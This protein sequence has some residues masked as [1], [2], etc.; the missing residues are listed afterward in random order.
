MDRLWGMCGQRRPRVILL[1]NHKK[2]HVVQA[3][4]ELRPWLAERAEVVA[5]P[6]L[7]QLESASMELAEAGGAELAL[8][9]GGDGTMLSQARWLAEY[10]VPLVGVNFGKLGF[11]AEFSLADLKAYWP[12]ITGGGCPSSQRLLVEVLLH[13]GAGAS[14]TLN[15]TAGA[16]TVTLGLNDAVIT[17]G[18][19]FRMLD[20]ELAVDPPTAEHRGTVFS[21]DGV[22]VAT[23]S[24]STAYNLSAGGPIVSPGIEALCITPICAYSLAFRPI[25]VNAGSTVHVRVCRAN[26]GTTLVI[27]GQELVGLQTGDEVVV[28]RYGRRLKLLHH[29]KIDFWQMLAQKMKWA[30]RP[31]PGAA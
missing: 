4:G 13:R 18:P 28:R 1:A 6:D 26:A 16:R 30:V 27:D 12:Q 17:C 24:G 21:G 3:L 7:R 14:W 9:L 29:P 10:D 2:P 15:G 31:G 11:L 19:P 23:P 5:E 20:L 8:V 25:V 22:I